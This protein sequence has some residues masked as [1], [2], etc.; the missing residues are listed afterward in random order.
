MPECPRCGQLAATPAAGPC[1][2]CR[3]RERERQGEP[4]QL[5]EPPPAQLP[6]QLDLRL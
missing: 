4:V 1:D 3:A 6:G 2:A 5:F